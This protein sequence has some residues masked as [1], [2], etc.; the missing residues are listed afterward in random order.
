MLRLESGRRMPPCAER[1]APQAPR[2]YPLR[3]VPPSTR[4]RRRAATAPGA[5]RS[6][7]GASRRDG[8]S[9]PGS[10]GP[11]PGRAADVRCTTCGRGGIHGG[12]DG[13]GQGASSGRRRP[14]GRCWRSNGA[15]PGLPPGRPE[16]S[17][18]AGDQE[19][20]ARCAR[21]YS[22]A[23]RDRGSDPIPGLRAGRESP[24]V[25]MVAAMAEMLLRSLAGFFSQ[26]PGN[27]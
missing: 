14:G 22:R 7:G 11:V 18:G 25:A 26:L 10:T 4:G 6:G 15:R 23:R 17:A 2:K 1:Q 24:V 3:P 16:G 19:P 20:E 13:C 21:I 27:G 5:G 9:T 12:T 8:R